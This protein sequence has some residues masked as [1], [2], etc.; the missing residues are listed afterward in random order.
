MI[1]RAAAVAAFI[2]LVAA[3]PAHA[4]NLSDWGLAD[5]RKVL[6]EEEITI[7]DDGLSE[8][9]PYI[10]AVSE[11]GLKFTI[12][13]TACKGEGAARRCQGAQLSTSFTMD[14][15]EA[16]AA[17]VKAL[18]YA[19]VSIFA[20]QDEPSLRVTRYIIFDHGIDPENLKTN[21]RV[22]LNIAEEIWDEI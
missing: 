4:A 15:N 1:M 10:D 9:D 17:K 5:M 19:A 13:G 18:D 20:D 11:E 21:I 12:Y 14:S 6:T 2:G 16:V 7:S 22:F 8:D 3:A